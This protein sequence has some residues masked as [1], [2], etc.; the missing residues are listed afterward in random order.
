M[1]KWNVFKYLH[2]DQ[3][4]VAEDLCMIQECKLRY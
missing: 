4:K 2:Y 1:S 3:P